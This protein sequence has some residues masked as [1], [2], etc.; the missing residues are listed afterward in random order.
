M[1]NAHAVDPGKNGSVVFVW[2]R[3]TGT[4]EH[5]GLAVQARDGTRGEHIIVKDD[6]AQ[7]PA[8][9]ANGR[10]IAYG[11]KGNI[12]IVEA[13]GTFVRSLDPRGDYPT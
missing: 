11:S 6:S 10:L 13:D 8:W 7:A 2:D 4:S 12:R 5:R 3:S 9:S 1:G